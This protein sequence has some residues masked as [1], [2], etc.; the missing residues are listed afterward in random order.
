MSL[1]ANQRVATEHAAS[2]ALVETVRSVLKAKGNH[3]WS[4]SPDATVYEA[5]ASM[6]ERRIGALVVLVNDNLA[7]IVSERD[8]ARKVILLGKSSRETY[9]RE[10]MTSPVTTVTPDH[11]VAECMHIMTDHRIRHLPVLETG[12]PAGM[13][14]IGDVVNAII[15]AQADTIRHLSGYITGEYP[16]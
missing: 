7:G 14:S 3:V 2:A 11:T 8:Y 15:S 16:A 10:I 4:I 6:A 9:V 1:S 13:I 12:Q 5:I